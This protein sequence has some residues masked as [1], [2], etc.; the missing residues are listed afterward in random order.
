MLLVFTQPGFSQTYSFTNYNLKEGLP[1]S[2]VGVFY[3]DSR[4]MLWLGTF[5]GLSSFNGKKF[6]SYSKA[7]GLLSNMVNCIVEDTTH[8]IIAGSDAGLS[9][10]RNNQIHNLDLNEEVS[11]LKKSNTGAIWG[12][13]GRRLFRLVNDKP[14]FAHLPGNS[15]TAI[16]T[17]ARGNLYAICQERGIMRLEGNAWKPVY[18]FSAKERNLILRRIIFDRNNPGHFFLLSRKAIYYGSGRGISPYAPLSGTGSDFMSIE[19]DHKGQLWAGTQTGAYLVR[20]SGEVLRFGGANGFTDNMVYE[21][22]RDVENNIWL[23]C[24]SQGIYKYEGDRYIRMNKVQGKDFEFPI[25]GMAKD[26]KGNLWIATFNKGVFRYDGKTPVPVNP[27]AFSASSVYF[28]SA[29]KKGRIWMSVHGHGLWIQDEKGLKQLIKPA[30]ED[31][32]KSEFNSILHTADG[33]IWLGR[34]IQLLYMQD[35]RLQTVGGFKGFV[36]SLFELNPREFVLAT[37][38]GVYMIR[39]RKVHKHLPLGKMNVLSLRRLGDQ[40]LVATLGDGLI[41]YNLKTGATFRYTTSNGLHSN[42]IYSLEFDAQKR[43]WMGTGRGIEKLSFDRASGRFNVVSDQANPLIIECNQNAILNYKSYMLVG[44]TGGIVACKTGPGEKPGSR[45]SVHINRLVLHSNEPGA[46]DSLIYIPQAGKNVELASHRDHLSIRFEGVFLTNPNSISYQYRLVGSD[47]DF[48]SPVTNEEVEYSNLEPGH[49]VFQVR[50]LAQGKSSPLKEFAFYVVPAFYETWW[51]KLLSTVLVFAIIYT[52]L[53]YW[54]KQKQ[55]KEKQVEAIRRA[56]KERIRTQTAEDFHDDI[57]NKL[58]RITVLSE[59]LDK[60]I[61]AQQIEEK[62]LIRLIRE[63]AGLLYTGTKDILWAL[64]PKSDNLLEIMNHVADVG[65]ELFAHT[66]VAFHV[67][68]LDEQYKKIHLSME[69]NRNLSLIFKEIL[70]NILKHAGAARV[71][72]RITRNAQNTIDIETEDDG[73]G[74]DPETASN[75][76]GLKNIRVRSER[77]GSSLAVSSAQGKGTK[78]TIFTSIRVTI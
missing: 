17:D 67:E 1:Q 39:D 37:T 5:G 13:A 28:V 6:T 51:F 23:S 55:R 44:T 42:D 52:G 18:L 74:F 77:I 65:Q 40:L 9:F 4:R 29:D 43:L 69:F 62:E 63:N 15:V 54:F 72:I 33:G 19:Q 24:F 34:G 46:R 76:N 53:R 7:S 58:T 36:S 2:Q 57:G 50:S 26:L 20:S 10:I 66:G 38:N 35:G 12:V 78:I 25:S 73:K 41:S 75:G 45:P 21:I 49:Y 11:F 70:N 60:K 64:D 27:S 3:Q 22:F 68:G 47:L 48:N 56:E 59:I 61:D 71:V 16:N 8:Q 32:T 30:E 31:I 14:V